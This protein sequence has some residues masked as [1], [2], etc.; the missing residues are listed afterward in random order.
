MFLPYSLYGCFSFAHGHCMVDSLSVD[1]G[2]FKHSATE[3]LFSLGVCFFWS[4]T[5]G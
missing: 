1:T 2:T 3:N 4:F 5:Q